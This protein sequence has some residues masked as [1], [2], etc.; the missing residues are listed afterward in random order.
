V[1]ARRVAFW[2]LFA[3]T[4]AIYY[5][6]V[7]WS[8]PKIASA[9][10]G[11]MPFDMRP[12]GYSFDEAKAF[13]GALSSD[14]AAFYVNVQHRLD[15]IYPALYAAT[16]FFAIR[17]LAPFRSAWPTLLALAAFP[18]AVFDYLEN[19]AVTA[20]LNAGADGLTPEL[21]ERASLWTLLKSVFTTIAMLLALVF[22]TMALWRRVFARSAAGSA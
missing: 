19:A 3:V 16:L 22:A 18:G 20:M 7:F 9:A 21:A 17:A 8:L 6:M 12:G 5:V 11:A 1:G 13:L 4:G 15:A 10:G 2:A 14:G